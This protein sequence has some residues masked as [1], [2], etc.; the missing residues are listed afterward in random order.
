MAEETTKQVRDLIAPWVWTA[1]EYNT[2][3]LD[4]A[5]A[6]PE[7]GRMMLNENPIPP[8]AAVVEAIT[9]IA[10]KGNRYPGPHVPS[11]HQAR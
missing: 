6:Q 5:W 11:A 3:I 4:K 1:P 9:D 2:G 10:K 7:M 8:S